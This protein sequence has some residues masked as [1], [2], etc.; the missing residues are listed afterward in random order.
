MVVYI[1]GVDTAPVRFRVFRQEFVLCYYFLMFR[2]ALTYPVTDSFLYAKARHHYLTQIIY[3]EVLAKDYCKEMAKFAP[4]DQA[5]EFLLKQ[6]SQEEEHLEM[7]TEY[8][9]THTRPVV[10]ISKYIKKMHTMMDKAIAEKDYVTCVFGQNFIVEA[11]NVSF[12]NE[13]AHH[14][15]GGLSELCQ[16][17]LKEE[18]AHEEFGV[19]EMKRILR[20]GENRKLLLLYRKTF[21]YAS[22]LALSLSLESKD[23]GIPMDEFARNT[24]IHQKERLKDIGL[25]LHFLDELLFSAVMRF[26]PVVS[27]AFRIK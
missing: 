18:L 1:H 6:Q 27:F 20:G 26:L 4:T 25:T 5:K 12:L 2:Y 19:T 16:K 9:T 21:F 7:L 24:I 3:G 13:I 11:L 15:D 22:L 14:A 10:S 23:I 8:V 17:I